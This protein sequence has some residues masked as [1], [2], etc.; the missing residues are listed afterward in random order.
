[1]LVEV[2][3]NTRSRTTHSRSLICEIARPQTR[4]CLIA[5]RS[6]KLN[7]VFLMQ[8][9]LEE[10]AHAAARNLTKIHSKAEYGVIVVNTS[11]VSILGI[12]QVARSQ[13]L[14]SNSYISTRLIREACYVICSIV[15][16]SPVG[17]LVDFREL[18]LLLSP[19]LVIRNASRA[20]GS[21]LRGE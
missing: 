21:V 7:A 18:E 20:G 11:I 5:I 19:D 9:E 10:R 13:E 12:R 15:P 16:V 3:L 14:A 6:F 8:T 4:Y 2:N 17:L 1:M